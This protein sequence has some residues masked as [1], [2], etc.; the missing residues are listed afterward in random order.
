MQYTKTPPKEVG[1][2]WYR[3]CGDGPKP[4]HGPWGITFMG[5]QE[6]KRT[7]DRADIGKCEWSAGPIE[8]PT[9]NA[10]E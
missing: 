8:E 4:S 10:D 5:E 6:V 1:W 9:E 3:Y 7:H 2:Y